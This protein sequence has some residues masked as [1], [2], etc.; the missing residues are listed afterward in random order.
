VTPS[1]YKAIRAYLLERDVDLVRA[2][3]EA[4]QDLIAWFA[5]L[6]PR[7]ELDRAS[8]LATG[9]ARLRDARRAG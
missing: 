9:L 3:D 6:S 4:D 8:Q 2:A 1:Q 5:T 7:Q